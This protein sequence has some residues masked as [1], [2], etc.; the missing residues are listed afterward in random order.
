MKRE[1]FE[2]Q[3]FDIVR[4]QHP[5]FLRFVDEKTEAV[6][7][8]IVRIVNGNNTYAGGTQYYF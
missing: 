2:S 1:I 4:K 5:D 8:D 3:C 6:A 7:G